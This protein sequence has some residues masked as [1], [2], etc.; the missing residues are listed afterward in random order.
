MTSP[1]RLLSLVLGLVVLSSAGETASRPASAYLPGVGYV[2]QTYNNCGPASI[3]SVL[4]YY[5]FKK[6]QDEVRL[7]LRP[8]GGY[9][10]ADVIDPYLRPFGLRATRFKNGSAEH[11]RRLVAQGVPVIVL[12]WLDRVGGIPH[13][14]VVRGYDDKSGVFWISDPIYGANV[15]LRYED[16]DT[17]WGV[18]GQ[19]FIPVYPEGWQ[20]RIMT[21]L[22]LK[23]TP[24]E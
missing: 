19:E 7:V 6:S 4:D 14:R 1:L 3:V 17:L 12:Q 21:I 24:R 2:A 15:Y 13:F 9:M 23:S 22:G 20:S 18:Y 5:G 11:L 16:F 8:N 10:K